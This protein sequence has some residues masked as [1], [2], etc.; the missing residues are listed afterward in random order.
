MKNKNPGEWR[1][2]LV[3][4]RAWHFLY[5]DVTTAARAFKAARAFYPHL[6][7]S[8]FIVSRLKDI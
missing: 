2:R 6:H 8:N 5:S 7:S 3:G 4:S 1:F